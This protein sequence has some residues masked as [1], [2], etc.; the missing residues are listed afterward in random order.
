MFLL[1]GLP[2]LIGNGLSARRG[3]S[4]TARCRALR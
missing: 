1:S 4:D 2:M 3:F